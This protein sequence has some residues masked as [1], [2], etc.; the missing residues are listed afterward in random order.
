MHTDCEIEMADM[1]NI[2][3]ITFQMYYF[4]NN[5]KTIRFFL[6]IC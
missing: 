3:F 5:K 2:F 1:L 4:Y 6:G